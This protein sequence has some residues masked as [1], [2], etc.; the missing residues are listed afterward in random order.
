MPKYVFFT[1]G[2]DIKAAVRE[3]VYAGKL[4]SEAG[5]KK[6]D[7]ETEATEERLAKADLK[8]YLEENTHAL[9]EFTGS[10]GFSA[11]I[12]SLLR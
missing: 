8:T 6:I 2:T 10:T 7:F 4:S 9:K 11:V 1:D 5:F 3:S 12:E